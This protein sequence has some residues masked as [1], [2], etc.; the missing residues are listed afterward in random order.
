MQTP[1]KSP[2]VSSTPELS[3]FIGSRIAFGR[4]QTAPEVVRAALRLLK[5]DEAG[6]AR[7]A[8]PKQPEPA[9]GLE[10]DA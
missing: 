9:C 2:N 6:L 8:Q 7:R 1:P 5:R 4:S 3:R 10:P